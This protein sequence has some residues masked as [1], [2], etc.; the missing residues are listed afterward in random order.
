[1]D[2]ALCVGIPLTDG[3]RYSVQ[4]RQRPSRVVISC[5]RVFA[6]GCLEVF[7]HEGSESFIPPISSMIQAIRNLMENESSW[8]RLYE[9]ESAT[10]SMDRC[11]LRN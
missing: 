4:L 3:L 7:Y 9:V 11:R 6:C 1:M 8:R 2:A 5:E 10:S